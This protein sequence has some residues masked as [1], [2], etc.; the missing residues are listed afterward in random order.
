MLELCKLP[1]AATLKEVDRLAE[2]ETG[3]MGHVHSAL[4]ILDNKGLQHVVSDLKV[5][6]DSL[7]TNALCLA[8]MLLFA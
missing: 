6:A 1:H 7:L 5:I 3:L 2:L 8:R 4:L